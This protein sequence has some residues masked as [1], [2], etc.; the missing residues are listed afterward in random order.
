MLVCLALEFDKYSLN[1]PSY[2]QLID[3]FFIPIDFF[4]EATPENI[5][6][7]EVTRKEEGWIYFDRNGYLLKD[8][9]R[10]RRGVQISFTFVENGTGAAASS[11]SSSAV[12]KSYSKVTTGGVKGSPNKKSPSTTSTLRTSA[13]KEPVRASYP[14]RPQRRSVERVDYKPEHIDLRQYYTA[15]QIR[16]T[17]ETEIFGIFPEKYDTIKQGVRSELKG[18]CEDLAG[19]TKTQNDTLTRTINGLTEDSRQV[20]TTIDTIESNRTRTIKDTRVN[21]LDILSALANKNEGLEKLNQAQA[22]LTEKQNELLTK[23]HQLNNLKH[24]NNLIAAILNKGDDLNT[25][26]ERLYS[27]FNEILTKD[28]EGQRGEL[29]RLLKETEDEAKEVST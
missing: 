10:K 21:T 23:E 22:K 12:R 3:S 26:R 5:S 15:P 11:S 2:T 9:R 17:S 25:D 29:L 19:Q 8:S 14:S 13:Q 28:L 18:R 27:K 20:N 6:G 4:R 7:Y 24:G 16:L 1:L